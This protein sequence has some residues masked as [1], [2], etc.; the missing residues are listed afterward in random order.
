MRI[1]SGISGAVLS[2]ALCFA[3]TTAAVANVCQPGQAGC[4]LPVGVSPPPVVQTPVT[5]EPVGEI[6]ESEGIGW[7]PILLGLAALG[8]GAYFLLD[9]DDEAPISP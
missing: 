8:L 3:S 5:G 7:L 4:V 6:I 2:V 1:V 9:D